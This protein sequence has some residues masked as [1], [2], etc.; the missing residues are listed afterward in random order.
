[1]QRHTDR[2]TEAR[3]SVQSRELPEGNV[4]WVFLNRSKVCA[5]LPLL[6]CFLRAQSVS[7]FF[8][9]FLLKRK[10]EHVFLSVKP[11]EFLS[12]TQDREIS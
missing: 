12:S 9:A 2:Q 1:M 6:F 10:L 7:V 5:V 11:S 8:H 4:T 3:K